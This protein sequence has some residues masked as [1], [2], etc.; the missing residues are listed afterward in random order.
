MDGPRRRRGTSQHCRRKAATNEMLFHS[1]IR[2]QTLV[3]LEGSRLCLSKEVNAL[4]FASLAGNDRQNHAASRIASRSTQSL[5][6]SNGQ[7]RVTSSSPV[8]TRALR[9]HRCGPLR[10]DQQLAAQLHHCTTTNL[11]RLSILPG[12]SAAALLGPERDIQSP[13]CVGWSDPTSLYKVC[14]TPSSTLLSRT[15]RKTVAITARCQTCR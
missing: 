15:H 14:Y 8:A 11:M 2:P 6:R 7:P 9:T 1:P 3:Q 13:S 4:D 5:E 12:Q 10:G